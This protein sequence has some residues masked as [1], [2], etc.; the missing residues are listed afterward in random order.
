MTY[1]VSNIHGDYQKFSAL[2]QD[3]AFKDSDLM[4]ILG[5]VVD[6]GDGSM[7]LI[8]DISV[9][10]NV[11]PVAG[12]HDLMAARM[13][14]G[15]D[16]M[17][18]SGETPSASY[19]GEM[20]AWMSN[21]GKPTL[22]AF[23]ALDEDAREGVLEYLGEMALYEETTVKGKDYLMVHAGI[24]GYTEGCD[25]DDFGPEDFFTETPDADYPPI[26]GKT[27]IVGH[28]PTP[29]G[30]INYGKGSIYLDCGV[31]NGGRLGCLCLET[32]EETY[33]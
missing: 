2:L 6:F 32:G 19:I 24:A 11:Y 3:I 23:R 8:E 9:R 18:R 13:L 26:K 5:D 33:I 28:R 21:G 31:A 1:V 25:L 29:D 17:L 22:D 14:S 20:N 10:L 27:L 4:Y 30:R 7:E 15:F 16:K 12:E